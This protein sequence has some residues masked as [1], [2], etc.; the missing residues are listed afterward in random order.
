MSEAYQAHKRTTL[1]PPEVVAPMWAD[2]GKHYYVGEL[3]Q[4]ANGRYV[5]LRSWFRRQSHGDVFAEAWQVKHSSMVPHSYFSA[6]AWFYAH[7]QSFYSQTNTYVIDDPATIEINSMSLGR[8]VCDII[9]ETA[10]GS[11]T[12]G[13]MLT[14]TFPSR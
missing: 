6:L 14:R 7:I 2:G 8:N 10:H 13:G 12:F 1:V 5:L 11:I 3:A 9:G 4:L